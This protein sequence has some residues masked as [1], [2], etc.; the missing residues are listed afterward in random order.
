MQTSICE[1]LCANFRLRGESTL[2][3]GLVIIKLLWKI[4]EIENVAYYISSE[5]LRD[6]ESE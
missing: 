5:S 4:K 3:C 6:A 1:Y 2:I